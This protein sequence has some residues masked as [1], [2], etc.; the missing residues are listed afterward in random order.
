MPLHKKVQIKNLEKVV[1][2]KAGIICVKKVAIVIHYNK[3]FEKCNTQY[4]SR[5]IAVTIILTKQK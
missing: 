4:L 2:L 1:I 5:I 3:L